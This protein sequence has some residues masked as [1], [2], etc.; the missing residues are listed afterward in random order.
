[1]LLP[2]QTPPVFSFFKLQHVFFKVGA[3]LL[4]LRVTRRSSVF[5]ALFGFPFTSWLRVSVT[6]GEDTLAG[7]MVGAKESVKLHLCYEN[8]SR[9]AQLSVQPR[10]IEES[11]RKRRRTCDENARA[12]CHCWWQS[13]CLKVKGLWEVHSIAGSSSRADGINKGS[14]YLFS[15][16]IPYKNMHVPPIIYPATVP[17]NPSIHSW[18]VL[19][20]QEI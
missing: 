20:Y 1:M 10:D 19:F 2:S 8:G 18:S 13:I 6:D 3:A 9:R 7:R 14:T 12:P 16:D 15:R 11:A 17:F 5:C 4:S